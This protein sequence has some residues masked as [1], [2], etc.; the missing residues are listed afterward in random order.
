[1]RVAVITNRFQFLIKKFVH[2]TSFSKFPVPGSGNRV[3]GPDEKVDVRKVPKRGQYLRCQSS[4]MQVDLMGRIDIPVNEIQRHETLSAAL[5]FHGGKFSVYLSYITAGLI[6]CSVCATVFRKV[7]MWDDFFT[8]ALNYFFD[9]SLEGNIPTFFSSFLLLTS[10][11]ICLL[12]FKAG[13]EIERTTYYRN[14][15]LLLSI[16][17]GFLSLDE[18]CRIHEQFSKLTTLTG[19]HAGYMHHSWIIPYALIALLCS[20]FFLKFLKSLPGR[21]RTLFL[22]SGILYVLA[23]VGF[24]PIEGHLSVIYQADNIYDKL[25]CNVEEMCE[26]GSIVLFIKTLINYLSLQQLSLRF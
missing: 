15:W 26:M 23:A 24:E 12:I 18:A 6:L 10:S 20:V 16:G 4:T 22:I 2:A 3:Q 5:K 13:K 21:T 19:E 8:N 1:M 25:L 14:C 11:F 9:V 7:Y 17:F